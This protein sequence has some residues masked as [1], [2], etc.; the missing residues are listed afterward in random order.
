VDGTTVT[1]TVHFE[2]CCLPEDAAER[3]V[4]EPLVLAEI[5]GAEDMWNQALATLSAKGCFDIKV[6]FDGRWLKNTGEAWDPGYHQIIFH[7]GRGVSFSTDPHATSANSVTDVVYS[8]TIT[9]LF[10]ESGMNELIWAHEIDHLM[11]LGDDYRNG[12]DLNFQG[13]GGYEDQKHRCPSD[14][15]G[16]LMCS[17]PGTIGRSACRRSG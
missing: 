4:Y 6:K 3:D 17:A 12:M 14:R 8:Q 2:L 11:G 7:R 5:K 9:G 15:E 16:T 1:I 10:Y 13:S